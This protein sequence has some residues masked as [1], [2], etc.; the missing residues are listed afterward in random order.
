MSI[1]ERSASGTEI[2]ITQAHALVDLGV[3]VF[4]CRMDEDGN[5]FPPKNWQRIKPNH[6][7]VD[8]WKKGM[9]LCAITGI[10]YDVID[11]DPRNGGLLSFKRLSN[12][13]GEDGPEVFWDVKTASGGRHLWIAKMDIGTRPGFLPG[14]DLKG[15]LPDGESRGFV[16]I[17][18]TRRPSKADGAGDGMVPY[19]ARGRLLPIRGHGHIHT[20]KAYIENAEATPAEEDGSA[21]PRRAS[22]ADLRAACLTAPPGG[23]HD[24]LL[25]YVHE[26]ERSGIARPIIVEMVFQLT[27]TMPVY[28][29]R[30]P[31][32]VKDIQIMLHAPGKVIGD[33]SP[34]EVA[35][36]TPIVGITT[37]LVRK[38]SELEQAVV[39]WL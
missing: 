2:S 27:Q 6:E 25:R 1:P 5:P 12:E 22:K 31:W 14:V 11:I 33:A 16:F 28:D 29:P 18:P 19:V 7:R 39:E 13:L 3:P 10:K 32:T 15:G 9:A 26:L 21:A 38:V 36:V 30:K 4:C 17:P 34:D 23:Q 8:S 24:A 35:G 37:G 20:L